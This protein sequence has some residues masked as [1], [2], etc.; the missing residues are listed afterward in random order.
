MT[1]IVV[2]LALGV[3]GAIA[4][5]SNAHQA[6]PTRGQPAQEEQ[7]LVGRE[8]ARPWSYRAPGPAR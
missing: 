3:S 6:E 7:V 5:R 1:P 4:A 2:G 8:D